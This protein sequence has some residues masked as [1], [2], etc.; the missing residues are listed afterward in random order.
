MTCYLIAHSLSDEDETSKGGH[1]GDQKGYEL[2][3]QPFYKNSWTHLY[4]A[5]DAEK[6]EQI[7]DFMEKAVS[8]G[9]IGY[10]QSER[11]TLF[12]A[13]YP[14]FKVE[15]LTKAVECDCSALVYCA[16]YNAYRVPF[17]DSAGSIHVAPTT[18]YYADY[19]EGK[20]SG[21]FKKIK[22]A[23]GF[24]TSEANLVRGDIICKDGHVA[25]WI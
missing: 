17:K 14:D 1:P 13:I 19:I 24:I 3:A 15:K 10:D 8:N 12:Q 4:R 25:V 11:N 2:C 7:A 6:A 18:A 16:L 21:N 23:E 22:P 5:N 20:L 9:Y